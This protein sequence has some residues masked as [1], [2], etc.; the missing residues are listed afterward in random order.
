MGVDI[1]R[2]YFTGRVAP[3]NYL[4]R[5]KLADLFLDC[6]PFNGGTTV[7]DALW[8]N[9][10]VLTLSGR[11]FASRMAGSLL[12]GV[13]QKNMISNSIDSYI[14][15]AIDFARKPKVIHDYANGGNYLFDQALFTKDFEAKIKSLSNLNA[16]Y[17]YFSNILF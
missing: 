3:E 17:Q 12:N 11:T 6:Y 10:P 16:Y 14:E 8:V 4:A 13:G 1:N 7:N 15:K 9:L 5:Y 2:L